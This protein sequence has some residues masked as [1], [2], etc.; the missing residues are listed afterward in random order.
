MEELSELA[1]GEGESGSLPSTGAVR[2]AIRA[3]SGTDLAVHSLYYL[4]YAVQPVD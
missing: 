2:E 1:T 4:V 3:L